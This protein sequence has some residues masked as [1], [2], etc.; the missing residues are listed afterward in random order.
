MK[1][2]NKKVGLTKPFIIGL[3]ILVFVFLAVLG[4][5]YLLFPQIKLIGGKKII[6]EYKDEYKEAGF[7]AYYL[8]KNITS[9]VKVSGS[10]D[11]KKLGE[12]KITYRVGKGLLSRRVVRSVFV[13]DNQK[14]KL[15]INNNPAYVCPGKE[16]QREEVTAVDIYD[17]D[18]TSKIKYSSNKRRAT[19][20]VSDSS[21][22][23]KSVTKMIKYEDV[24]GP[25]IELVGNSVID[26]CVNDVY[27]EPGYKVTDNCDG[28]LKDDVTID[29][30]VD[31]SLVGEYKLVYSAVD[32]AGN[33]GKA[34][35]VVRVNNGDLPGVVYLTFDDGPNW[36]TTD[37][38]LDIL[39]EEGVEATFFVT[40]HGPDELIVREYNEGHTVALHTA[41]HDYSIVYSSDEAYFNDLG[42]VH[43]RVYRLTGYDSKFIRF[44]GGSSNTISRRYSSGIMSRL[45]RSVLD[46]GY[47][48]YD[49]NISSGDAGGTNKASEVYANVVNG[50]RKDR[51]NMVLMH[52]VKPHTRDALRDIIH[53]CKENGYTIKKIDNCTTMVTQ[54]VAN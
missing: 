54:K 26:M 20:T 4:V 2:R 45:S 5:N 40:N 48:Y 25:Y 23:T 24:E 11:T 13:E 14:P 10:V 47:K 52:D 30:I 9:Q 1:K 16:Y 44:P 46:K 29:G 37:A 7:K 34:E 38:I 32:K 8:G 21:G 22:N 42:L 50:L 3:C 51:V 17:G 12:Y 35:R 19:Y 27:K 31:N 18:I 39:K 49:W 33:K 41:T 43:D 15:S 28:D 36:G 53:Y 6:L